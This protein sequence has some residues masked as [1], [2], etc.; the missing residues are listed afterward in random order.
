MT[1]IRPLYQGEVQYVTYA[2]SSKSGPR[3]TLRLREREELD[4]FVG[5]EGKRFAC[6]L[7]LIG[8][9]EQPALPPAVVETPIKGGQFARLAGQWCKRPD[10]AEWIRPIYDRTMGGNGRGW[11]DVTPDDFTGQDGSPKGL[12]GYARHA[13]LLLCQVDER[14]RLDHDPGAAALFDRLIRRPFMAHLEA[15]KA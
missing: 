14:K 15:T 6:V 4:A 11:G 5:M 1:D 9:D 10:F 7:V 8:D 3:V 13:I 12:E 2:D